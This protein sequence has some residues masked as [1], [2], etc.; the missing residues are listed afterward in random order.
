MALAAVK[1][2]AEVRRT[3]AAVLCEDQ[4]RDDEAGLGAGGL[5]LKL[6]R[7]QRV[8]ARFNDDRSEF[9]G[10]YGGDLRRWRELRRRGRLDRRRRGPGLD[11]DLGSRR[12]CR[13]RLGG[14]GST[15][16]RGGVLL[17]LLRSGRGL[18]LPAR[19]PRCGR[20]GGFRRRRRRL[21]GRVRH[22]FLNHGRRRRRCRLVQPCRSPAARTSPPRPTR[23]RHWSP[24]RTAGRRRRWRWRRR[25]FVGLF[26]RAA[27][28]AGRGSSGGR[29]RRGPAGLSPRCWL[30]LGRVFFFLVVVIVV[31]SAGGFR[32][33]S[34][35][36]ILFLF[37]F[38]GGRLH[39]FRLA[40]RG[41]ATGGAR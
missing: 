5:L 31:I 36:V 10:G 32:G 14:R 16:V 29:R 30:G 8:A 19:R 26:P 9:L 34:F 21:V 12:L 17:L 15:R 4:V 13:R 1:V 6:L 25:G 41:G 23:A 18:W 7:Q 2:P 28:S 38:G 20:T 39:D 33:R 24:A 11:E 37:V 40:L 22:F 3:V 27:F 35:N